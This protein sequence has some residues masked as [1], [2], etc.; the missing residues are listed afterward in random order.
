MI[1]LF[2]ID[3]H[4]VLHLLLFLSADE[5]TYTIFLTGP[6]ELRLAAKCCGRLQHLVGLAQFANFSNRR[7]ITWTSSVSTGN[8]RVFDFLAQARRASLYIPVYRA[9]REIATATPS[10]QTQTRRSITQFIATSI[11]SHNLSIYLSEISGTPPIN[12]GTLQCPAT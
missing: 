9:I 8:S 10:L 7:I 2:D 5:E 1:S 11:T 12:Q 3:R 4:N 6:V